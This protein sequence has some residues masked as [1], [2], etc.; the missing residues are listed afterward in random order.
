MKDGQ[1]QVHEDWFLKIGA[2]A[3]ILVFLYI[4][5]FNKVPQQQSQATRITRGVNQWEGKW[6]REKSHL[7]T[8]FDGLPAG[9][10]NK[11][12]ISGEMFS[13]EQ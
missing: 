4:T 7:T 5:L 1:K 10:F 11:P 13:G 9:L 8:E 3:W 12:L 2:P 6:R